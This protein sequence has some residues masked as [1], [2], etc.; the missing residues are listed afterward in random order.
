MLRKMLAILAITS[1]LY[2]P[3]L[4]GALDY[5]PN[6]LAEKNLIGKTETEVVE[7]LGAPKR[8]GD[9]KIKLTFERGGAKVKGRSLVWIHQTSANDTLYLHAVKTC[10][11]RG[12]IAKVEK[13][14][15][16]IDTEKGVLNRG[17]AKKVDTELAKEL[18]KGSLED[19]GIDEYEPG[20]LNRPELES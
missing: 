20:D 14:F 9:C 2:I 15:E 19:L 18:V 11:V 12:P 13:S 10:S 4:T 1:L 3:S 8:V 16:I 5:T 17:Y 6:I 7:S